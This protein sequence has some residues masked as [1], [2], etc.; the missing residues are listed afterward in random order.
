MEWHLVKHKNGFTLIMSLTTYPYICRN[1]V[2]KF[3]V[4]SVFTDGNFLISNTIRT[5]RKVYNIGTSLSHTENH[6][7]FKLSVQL[8]SYSHKLNF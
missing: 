2:L 1:D 5:S 6:S 4:S 8:Y 7:Q 3:R